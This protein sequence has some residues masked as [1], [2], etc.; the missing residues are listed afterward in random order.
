MLF[1]F[2]GVLSEE[3]F[4][5]GLYHIAS[6]NAVDPDKF[7]TTAQ[8]LIFSSGYIMGRCSEAFFWDQLRAI[9]GIHGS[10]EEFK[11]IILE[12]FILREWMVDLAKK[13]KHASIRTAILSD[14]T[15]WLDE[16]D[17]RLHFFFLFESIFNSYHQGKSK[18]DPSLFDDVL[19]YMKLKPGETLFIDDTLG[20][21]ERARLKGL[22]A[23]HFVDRV[24][25]LGEM[26]I[27][28]PELNL[29]NQ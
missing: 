29:A 2:G 7:F 11:N 22:N 10:N 14:Q 18:N 3:G 21:V 4:R 9:T 1:D 15:N 27:F 23:F 17:E 8:S 26:K 6:L 19:S 24:Q 16:L 28:F 20:N 25:F 12:R 5:M 13:L